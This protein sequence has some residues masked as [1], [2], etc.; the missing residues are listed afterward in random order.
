[1]FYKGWLVTRHLNGRL[2][3][4]FKR[5]ITQPAIAARNHAD[6]VALRLQMC[7]QRNDQRCLAGATRD[8]IADHHDGDRK[9]FRFEKPD[10]IK[11]ASRTYKQ[12]VNLGYWPQN[13]GQPA[14]AKPGFL[15]QVFHRASATVTT[16]EARKSNAHLPGRCFA[17]QR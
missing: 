8:D 5:V 15:Q 2:R 17:W 13:P 4:N 1:M 11:L 10:A 14:P 6:V 16:V 12:T 9:S 7:G 3:V